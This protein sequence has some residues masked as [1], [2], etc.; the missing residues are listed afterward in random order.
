MW[1]VWVKILRGLC[2]LCGSTFCV[3]CVGEI[4]FCVGQFFCVGLCVG[5]NFLR[6]SK[7]ILIGAFIIIS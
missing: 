4:Y 2:G 5:H 6:G 7:K 1:V 3:D